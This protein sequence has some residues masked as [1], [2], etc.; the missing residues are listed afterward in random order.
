M[1]KYEEFFIVRQDTNLTFM[2]QHSKLTVGSTT[3]M[4]SKDAVNFSQYEL[5]YEHLPQFVDRST[6][7]DILFI[8][9]TV[10]KFN[11]HDL[12]ANRD[13][14]VDEHQLE[15]QMKTSFWGD[16]EVKFFSYFGGLFSKT[17]KLN[18][19]KFRQVIVDMKKYV[20]EHLYKIAKKDSD[21]LHQLKLIKDFFLL[22]RGDQFEEFIK[23]CR[24]LSGKNHL[25]L[26]PKDLNRAFQ[27]AA[28]S[29]NIGDDLDQFSFCGSSE[30]GGGAAAA[31]TN[32]S[33][34]QTI[35]VDESLH[36]I[37]MRYKVKWPLH[38]IFSAGV[39]ERYNEIF[40][41][42]LRI[43]KAQH[44]LQLVWTRHREQKMDLTHLAVQFRNKLM[45]F[46]DNMFM[47]LQV[48]VVES[49]FSAL[50]AAI[51]SCEDFLVIQRE[52]SLFQIMILS[53]CFLL[54]SS[55]GGVNQ[56]KSAK[57]QENEVLMSLEKI[58]SVVNVFAESQLEEDEAVFETQVPGMNSL[59]GL[60]D[61]FDSLIGDL[62]LRLMGLKSGE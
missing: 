5:S 49:R 19:A 38:M 40:R 6:A 4:Q 20:T 25:A 59:G 11:S 48:D 53:H 13:L 2:D 30:L 62:M 33:H 37:S 60:S 15:F 8:G 45:F 34:N 46:I 50:I 32:E 36:H 18:L 17:E 14:F 54:S 12:D 56:T 41:F 9:Q 26:H 44:D 22:G 23:E 16:F 7:E 35:N 31:T 3:T 51:R 43:K 29:L 57:V 55:C 1:D 42:L 24:M 61:Q 52:H 27:M 39:M 28:Q 58:L 47:Y 21:L 10:I